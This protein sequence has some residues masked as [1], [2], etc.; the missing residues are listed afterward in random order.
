[1]GI[2]TIQNKALKQT[3]MRSFVVLLWAHWEGSVR[4][5]S[6]MFLRFLK[7][8]NIGLGGLNENFYVLLKADGVESDI[9]V[10]KKNLF[11]DQRSLKPQELRRVVWLLGL[12]YSRFD[13]KRQL[14]ESLQKRRNKI[15]FGA[16][17]GISDRDFDLLV[18]HT[19]N[20]IGIFE[21]L[22]VYS[23]LNSTYLRSK[24]RP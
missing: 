15:A 17:I 3:I 7:G 8:Q 14:M 11:A 1:M 16:R 6:D 13:S 18:N 12:D 21:D 5:I 22:I 23:V 2:N 19:Q 9:G 10:E 24:T 4:D 20:L